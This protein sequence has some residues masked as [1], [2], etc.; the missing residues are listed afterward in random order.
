MII[1]CSIKSEA[2]NSSQLEEEE[3][4]ETP[5]QFYAVRC[6][7]LYGAM[8]FAVLLCIVAQRMNGQRRFCT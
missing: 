8:C 4:E 5:L 6:A 2:Y 7:V 3:A 1:C